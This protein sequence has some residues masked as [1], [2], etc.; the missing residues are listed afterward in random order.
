MISKITLNNF[1]NHS[2]KSFQFDDNINVIYGNNGAGKTNILEA[3][4]LFKRGRGLRSNDLEEMVYNQSQN[5]TF[6]IYSELRNHKEIANCATSF[7]K[8]NGKR[9]FQV[10]N[11]KTNSIKNFPAI[12]W[13]T[14]KMDNI[15]AEQKT[16]RR[17]F[18]D[19]I[20]SDIDQN[21]STRINSYEKCLKERMILLLQNK[22]KKWL[23][24]IE[25]K[26]AEL[27]VAIAI[28]RNETIE[29]LNKA[30]LLNES[31]F[32]KINIEIIGEIEQLAQDKKALEVEEL[33]VAK[34]Y[35]NRSIDYQSGRNL[36]GVHR[37]DFTALLLNKNITANL[38]STGEQKSILIAI[39]IARA[40]INSFFNQP[41]SILLLDEIVSHLDETK[42][43][44][45]FKELQ[46]LDIQGFLTGTD[47][48]IFSNLKPSLSKTVK[49]I[50]LT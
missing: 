23:E 32:I 40:R 29:H 6:T 39:T 44:D 15:F 38:C 22:D 25:R 30:I 19:K 13:L 24:I 46:K 45:L 18:L 17:K 48:K 26:I 42:K 47:S 37:S 14:P 27:G 10:N 49:L 1:R 3:I 34:L 36:F 21:H 50:H 11:T 41:K 8:T 31:N 9:I 43:T 20:V 28:A 7:D 12:I 2:T 5:N 33:F 4:S 16:I 35:Q